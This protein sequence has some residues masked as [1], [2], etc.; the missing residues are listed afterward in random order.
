VRPVLARLA[1]AALLAAALAP[2][3]LAA[4]EPLSPDARRRAERAFVLGRLEEVASILGA[5]AAPVDREAVV[6]FERYWRPGGAAAE[7]LPAAEDGSVSAR[8]LRWLA[9]WPATDAEDYPLPAAGEAEP[10]PVLTALVL[11]RRRRESRGVEGLPADGPL[12]ATTDEAVTAFLH[13]ARVAFGAPPAAAP[14]AAEPDPDAVLAER[15]AALARRNALVATLAGAA[16][17]LFAAGLAFAVSR[18]RAGPKD[19]TG[20]DA[21]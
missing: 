17:L 15:V 10:W 14:P 9:G 1:L 16:F 12:A 8:R 19:A 13:H 21:R 7:P 4:P 5:S 11:D 2:A 18:P 20:P 6:L 3:A